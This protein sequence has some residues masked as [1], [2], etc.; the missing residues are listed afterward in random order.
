MKPSRCQRVHVRGLD[1]NLRRWGAENAPPLLLLHGSRDSSA[2]FQFFVDEL[3]NEWSIYAPDWR[4]HGFSGHAKGGYWFHDFVADLDA[5]M[6]QLFADKPVP[7]VGHSL[8]GN[9][10]SIYAGLKPRRIS[11]FVSLD[12]FGAL[13]DTV[14]VHAA[15][16]LN[17]FLDKIS[18][19]RTPAR[20]D[21]VEEM[22]SR[23]MA[24][25]NRLSQEKACFLAEN[26]SRQ[27]ADGSFTWLF[28]PNHRF[29][30]PSL[31]TVE[32]WGQVWANIEAPVLWLVSEDDR[33]VAPANNPE[34]FSQRIAMMPNLTLEKIP[35]TGH[36]LHHDLPGKVA[37]LAEAFL[38]GVL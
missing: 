22:A 4:G 8:G 32:E 34:L 31:H 15:R 14:P 16:M 35:Q 37:D 1:Y 3:K 27:L 20:Y 38:L 2:S 17:N 23:L 26:S 11:R 30:L 10:G 13:V 24:A 5:L 12:G 9:I 7:V 28:D 18:H 25:N 36:N 33:N 29:T 21:S 19:D 6:T